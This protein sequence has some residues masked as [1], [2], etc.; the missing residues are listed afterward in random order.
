MTRHHKKQNKK[1][2]DKKE[3]KGIEAR[4]TLWGWTKRKLKIKIYLEHRKL[5]VLLLNSFSE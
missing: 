2:Q 5:L 3:K 4:I 1:N